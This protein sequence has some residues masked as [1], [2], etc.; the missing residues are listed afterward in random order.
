[1]R[2][3]SYGAPIFHASKASKASL[4]NQPRS[5]GGLS[6]AALGRYTKIVA[7]ILRL[8]HINKH[9]RC[10]FASSEEEKHYVFSTIIDPCLSPGTLSMYQND[11]SNPDFLNNSN[12]MWQ[13]GELD[14]ERV[15]EN[16][17]RPTRSTIVP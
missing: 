8:A 10:T 17:R 6:S 2:L 16:H 7:D 5:R 14:G 1:M 15:G 13:Y 3:K 4:L 9:R 12:E 11:T